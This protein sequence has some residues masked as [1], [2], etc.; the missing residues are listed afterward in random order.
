M[1]HVA[2]L[3]LFGARGKYVALLVGLSFAV[4][5]SVQQAAIFLGILQRSTGQLQNV[6]CADIWVASERTESIEI[7][8]TLTEKDLYRVRS[9]PGVAWAEPLLSYSAY[10]DLPDGRFDSVQLIGLDR[11]TLIGQP[12]EMIEG[13]LADLRQPD[14]VFL[15]S[16]GR[17]KLSG[18]RVGDVLRLN[19]HRARIAGICRARPGLL[20]KPLLYTT[21]ENAMRFVPL[22]RRPISYIL[23]KAQPGASVAQVCREIDTLPNVIALPADE[24]R[25]RTIRYITFRTGVGVNFLMTVVL[26][27]AVGL[28]VSTA[29]FNQFTAD[30]LPHFAMLKAIG[31]RPRTL[32]GLLLMQAAVV[33]LISYGIGVGLA[34]LL[35]LPGLAPDAELSASFP[36]QVLVGG[37]LP[38]LLCVSAGCL[39]NLRRVIRVDPG[40][41]FR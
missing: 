17:K 7:T 25:W 37:L 41:L 21:A 20:S 35:T 36:W 10:V 27:L 6:G 24:L 31:T 5:L 33:G 32:A 30:Y 39:F 34:G 14:A 40:M 9:T 16:S 1:H 29:A 13:S 15:E 22:G 19:D 28:V 12:P 4:L 2:L 3:M 18:L 8:R 11:A 38:M 26:G 23:V